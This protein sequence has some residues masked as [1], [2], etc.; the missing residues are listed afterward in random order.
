MAATPQPP[1]LDSLGKEL[2]AAVQQGD[3]RLMSIRSSMA[4]LGAFLFLTT[5]LAAHDL[6]LSYVDLRINSDGIEAT[7]EASAKNFARELPSV[8]ETALLD[9][10]GVDLE[11]AHLLVHIASALMIASDGERL[12][13]Q[14]RGVEP[15]PG[16]RD[17]R[18]QIRFPLNRV[19]NTINV[20]CEL[21]ATDPRHKTFLNIYQG[22]TLK[23][24]GQ[25]HGGH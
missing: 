7:I 16:K 5:R 3:V 13:P 1:D 17:L 25:R 8:G 24:Q 2:V 12:E 4:L 6:P 11:K 20:H 9:R 19:G 10:S 21:F 18:V 14:L 23:Y 22:D 15:L